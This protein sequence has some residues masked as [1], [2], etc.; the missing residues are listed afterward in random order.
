MTY[1]DYYLKFPNLQEAETTLYR[2]EGAVEANKEL[3]IEASEGYLVPNYDNI[4]IIGAIYKPTGE[5]NIVDDVEVPVM[6]AIDGWHVNVRNYTEAPEL[7]AYAVVPTN[8]R[9]VWA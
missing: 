7:H 4:D 2:I 1:F 3:G 5:V 9:R 8:P 6:E